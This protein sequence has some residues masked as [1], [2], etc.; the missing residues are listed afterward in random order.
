MVDTA[1]LYELK[2]KGYCCS[3][4][5]LKLGMEDTQMDENPELI[6]AARGLC[7]GLH[8]GLLCGILSSAACLVAM[9]QPEDAGA[10][11]KELV[12][13]FRDEYEEANG[14]ITCK[15]ILA[16]DQMN[17]TLKCPKILEATYDKAME[18]LLDNGFE[19]GREY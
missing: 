3:Q 5:L 7:D 1:R 16:G 11:T 15:D 9:L 14:G 18:M 2:L 17:K 4:I 8:S 19:I 12:E 10:L 13:W 6:R